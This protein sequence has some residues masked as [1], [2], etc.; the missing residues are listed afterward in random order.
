M[1]RQ[2][3]ENSGRRRR[4]RRAPGAE[5]RPPPLPLNEEGV[6]LA[7]A[8]SPK[9]S[10]AMFVSDASRTLYPWLP[11]RVIANSVWR[12][13]QHERVKVDESGNA[14]RYRC[15]PATAR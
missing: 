2:H 4:Q 14:E 10:P 6:P 3:H 1:N 13:P 8:D 5:R 7:T 12:G 9:P 15:G 11:V